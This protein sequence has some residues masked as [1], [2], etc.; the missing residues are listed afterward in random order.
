VVNDPRNISYPECV[1]LF[2][3]EFCIEN[4]A[5][6]LLVPINAVISVERKGN[7]VQLLVVLFSISWGM[8]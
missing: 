7:L 5:L 3:V 8:G 6:P 2:Q 1:V 4:R